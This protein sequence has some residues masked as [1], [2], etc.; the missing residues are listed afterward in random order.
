MVNLRGYPGI[1]WGLEMG[2]PRLS[3]V[4]GVSGGFLDFCDRVG[5]RLAPLGRDQAAIGFRPLVQQVGE[6]NEKSPAL[7]PGRARPAQPTLPSPVKADGCFRLVVR[8]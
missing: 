5:K 8:R 3:L 7:A 2:S 6:P 1:R 4:A